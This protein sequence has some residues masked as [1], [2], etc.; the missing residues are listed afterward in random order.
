M[1]VLAIARYRFW[2]T[3]RS[4]SAIAGLAMGPA[5]AGAI[6]ESASSNFAALDASLLAAHA[7]FAFITWLAHGAILI[8]ASEA[9]GSVKQSRPDISAAISD[10][11][12]SA[13]IAPRSRFAGEA[14]GILATTL[15]IHLCSLPA[16]LIA[17]VLSPLPLRLFVC[18]EAVLVPLMVLSSASAAWKRLSPRTG[19][20]STRSARS[21]L[22]FIV[23]A[24]LIVIANVDLQTFRDSAF[25]FFSEP[26][27]RK[28]RL[29]VAGVDNPFVLFLLFALLYGAYMTFY[30][31]SAVRR[32]DAL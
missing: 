28:W 26:S 16:L 32:A 23:L 4:S 25:A 30:F 8:G 3:L 29:V 9:F 11:M 7:T 6:F 12:D 14:L 20:V 15:M 13:P 17:A 31:V 10:L 2:T 22:L 19:W 21:G 24:S 1:R 18:I 27:M 5:V